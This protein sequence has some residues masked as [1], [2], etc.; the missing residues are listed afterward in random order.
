LAV[1]HCNSI[2][3]AGAGQNDREKQPYSPA[4][5]LSIRYSGRFVKR[6]EALKVKSAPGQTRREAVNH[7]EPKGNYASKYVIDLRF[8]PADL[9]SMPTLGME[10]QQNDADAGAQ[11]PG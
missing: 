8:E 5:S 9:D 1:L 10:Q 11:K 2:P 6:S 7:G 4:T 3:F